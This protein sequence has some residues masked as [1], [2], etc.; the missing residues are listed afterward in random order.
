VDAL[1]PGVFEQ[2]AIGRLLDPVRREAGTLAA[3][4]ADAKTRFNR[5]EEGADADLTASR[6][7]ALDAETL[8]LLGEPTV[9]LRLPA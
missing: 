1:Y 9:A 7:R 3:L 6:L 2:S 5:G 8:V 4:H